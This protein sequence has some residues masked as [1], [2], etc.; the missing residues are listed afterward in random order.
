MK[1]KTPAD[2][3]GLL[4]MGMVLELVGGPVAAE[5]L[6]ARVEVQV[7]SQALGL[8]MTGDESNARRYAA[9]LAANVERVA[10]RMARAS[11]ALATAYECGS[12]G[13][14]GVCRLA[15]GHD[16]AHELC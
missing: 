2:A 7:A 6:A 4:T 13:A 11:A 15:T 3:P 5:W 1:Q 8:A 10:V 16:G 12:R 14:S 9:A